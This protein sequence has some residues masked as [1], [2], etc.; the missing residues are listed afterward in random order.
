MSSTEHKALILP[1]KGSPLELIT[2]PTPTPGPGELLIEVKAIAFNPV[3]YYQRDFGFPA[4]NYPAVIGSDIAGTVISVGS[5]VPSDAPKPGSRV[6]AF[7]ITF[8]KQGDPD[9]GAFQQRVIVPAANVVEL[10]QKISFT[11]ASLLPM[12]VETAWAGLNT[13]GVAR[14]TAFTTK[15]KKGLLVWGASSSIGSAAVQI[16][17][18]LGFSVYATASTKHHAYLK[19]LGASRTFDYK[20]EDVVKEIV[21]AAKEDGITIQQCF[22]AT[23]DLKSS[24]EAV[25][26]C[27]GE[28]VG[29]V[30]TAVPP[31]ADS[32]KVEDV[33]V[34]FVMMPEDEK[35]RLEFTHFI[36]GVWLKEKLATGEFVPSP[37]IQVVEG[38]LEGVS[39]GIDILKAGVSATKI[40][41]EL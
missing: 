15:D 28:G 32:P 26:G 37:H 21:A 33:E 40:V 35:D 5:S 24:S 2:R 39:K 9:Y 30:G 14:D 36:F 29:K 34:T 31:N 41:V 13:L 17:R 38:G 25:K 10:P 11:E 6:A 12:S 3:D 8:F 1:A 23:G 27:K 18:V 19:S 20:N 16:G 7:A 22:H 4:V